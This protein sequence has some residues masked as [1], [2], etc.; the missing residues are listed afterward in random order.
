MGYDSSESLGDKETGAVA[1]LPIWINFMKAAIAGKDD[2]QFP[3]DDSD[4]NLDRAAT[5]SPGAMARRDPN[6]K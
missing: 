6:H 5:G 4:T 2:E 3:G 1:A